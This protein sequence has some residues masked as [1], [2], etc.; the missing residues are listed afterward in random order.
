MND[1]MQ[2]Q[3]AKYTKDCMIPTCKSYKYEA[4]VLVVGS[5]ENSCSHKSPIFGY[6]LNLSSM[7]SL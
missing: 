6:D 2:K 7:G 5:N 1:P 3:K 4:S